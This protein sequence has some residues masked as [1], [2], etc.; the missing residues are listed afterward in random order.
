MNRGP[1]HQFGDKSQLLAMEQLERGQGVGVVVS[2]RDL[3]SHKAIEYS[4]R[5]RR[6]GAEVLFDP[7][8][9]IPG[10]TNKNI[11][12]YSI[13]DFRSSIDS[14]AQVT[15]SDL[16]GIASSL[17]EIN[18]QLQSSAVLAPA[19][20]YQAARP[21]ILD[22][23]DKLFS[24]AK[25]ASH[26]LGLPV[27]SSVILGSSATASP[28]PL[29]EVLSRAT[30]QPADGWYFAFQFDGERIP[31]STDNLIRFAEALLALSSTGLPV[32]HAYAGPLGLLSF[33]FGANGVGVAHFQN[34]WKF[35]PHRWQTSLGQ[36]GGGDAPPR[37]FSTS[38]WGTIIYPDELIRL[39]QHLEQQI[40]TPS[41]F[42]GP[43]GTRPPR[44]WDRWEANKH[45]VYS[46]CRTLA[47]IA[48]AASPIQCAN[49][50]RD[51]L[52]DASLLLDE[53]RAQGLILRDNA[54]S[55]QRNWLGVLD[56]ILAN[57]AR[58]YEYLRL[59]S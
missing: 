5:Y 59:I 44:D 53:I 43:V 45:L 35:S 6:F 39:T 2:P 41:P 50:A 52:E 24:A 33:G 4:P 8:F 23:N 10:F 11:E 57:N 25:K 13:N 27:Y 37:F 40:V 46:I 38:L 31:S 15:A 12:S 9:F 48:A 1:W 16:N 56:H 54:G 42:S 7:Q 47:H 14:L 29:N 51:V 3:A 26:E 34:L 49:D 18:G 36:G 28:I 19:V 55:Y 22:L 21:D 17:V 30:A 20:V 32:L 58:D